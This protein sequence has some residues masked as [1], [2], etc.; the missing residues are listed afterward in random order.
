LYKNPICAG[1]GDD[2]QGVF[3]LLIRFVSLTLLDDVLKEVIRIG[4]N[5]NKA[6]AGSRLDEWLASNLIDKKCFELA[7][8]DKFDAFIERRAVI[9]HEAV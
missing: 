8:A 9:I 7:K 2:L 1:I 3:E 4:V 5:T 6:N